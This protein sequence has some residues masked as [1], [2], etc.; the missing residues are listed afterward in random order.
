MSAVGCIS[1]LTTRRE[2]TV[3]KHAMLKREHVVGR[4]ASN[5]SRGSTLP[6][7]RRQGGRILDLN[8]SSGAPPHSP[9][10][11][12]HVCR[13]F[14]HVPINNCDNASLK[15]HAAT[16]EKLSLFDI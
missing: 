8:L 16:Y 13:R 14:Y 10:P 5:Q 3:K 9:A 6:A 1:L 2:D 4:V 7:A 12:E 11:L 15:Q